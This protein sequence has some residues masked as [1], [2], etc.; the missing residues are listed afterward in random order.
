M[1]LPMDEALVMTAIDFSGRSFINFDV[2]FYSEKIGDFD[3]ELVN[4]FFTALATN[5]KCTL[6]ISQ[7]YGE[8]A[9]H[10]AEAAFKS[11]A[12]S[13]RMAVK[14]DSEYADEIPS[15]KGVL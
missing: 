2:E 9:H 4:E 8:N 10:I 1:L 13:I 5:A 7:C 11:V 15:T 14:V 3:T 12:R 6:H